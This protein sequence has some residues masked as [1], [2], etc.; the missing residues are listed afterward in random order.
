MLWNARCFWNNSLLSSISL[1][2]CFGCFL[3][4]HFL[5]T[6]P[7]AIKFPVSTIVM[8][9]AIRKFCCVIWVSFIENIVLVEFFV[10]FLV[11]DFGFFINELQPS[12]ILLTL[13][14]TILKSLVTRY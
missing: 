13:S 11:V 2:K 6:F 1:T 14:G 7:L 4:I 8:F 10:F 12:S 5:C 9:T 3:C